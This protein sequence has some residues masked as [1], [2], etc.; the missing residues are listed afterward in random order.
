[1]EPHHFR[2]IID[3][4]DDAIISETLDGIVTS[5]NPGAER[6]LGYTAQEALGQS[7]RMLIGRDVRDD[8]SA[9]LARIAQGE[10]V[11]HFD[12]V[13]RHKDG[14]PVDLSVTISP[15]FDDTHT[16]C[17]ASTIAHTISDRKRIDAAFA[18]SKDKFHAIYDTINDAIFIHD[19]ETGRIVDVNESACR[20]YGYERARL[21][22]LDVA[23]LSACT[24]QRSSQ[25]AQAFIQLAQEQGH[26]A[27]EWLARASSGRQFWVEVHLKPLQFGVRKQILAVVR[28]IDHQKQAEETLKAALAEAKALNAQLAEAQSHLLQSEKLA[29]IG[30]LAA[31]VAHELNNPIGF[32]SSNLGTLQ[33]YLQDIF[34]VISAYEA[35]QTGSCAACAHAQAVKLLKDQ[36][37][38]AYLKEDIFPL[39]AQSRDGLA[40]V[41]KIVLDL[42][43]FS[44][45]GESSQGWADLHQG[46]DST[47]NIVWNQLRYKCTV[48]KN[49]GQVPHVLC[50][51]SQ[52]NQVFMNLLLNAAQAIPEHGQITLNTG[53]HEEHVFV[54]VSDTGTGIAP[55]HLRRIFDPFFTTKPVGQG[56]GLGLSLAYSIV[57]KHQGRI[58]VESDLGR[59]TTFTVWLPIGA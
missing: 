18:Q 8:P 2:L 37:D 48:V 52:I 43:D 59:G 21:T 34:A 42:K 4:N 45:A 17:G 50:V 26:Q 27:F 31:G 56:T 6:I 10:R 24:G 55:D 11:H 13:R 32:V 1:M 16:L 46:L 54:A 58:E 57:Q 49:Y 12:T 9:I 14:R 29:S 41:T 51:A 25:A 35:A 7:T 22:E 40:R 28:D 36:Q 3:S 19:A 47:L 39:L 5:W 30:Q 23:Q 44:R 20:M 33:G 15:I 53:R 38:F